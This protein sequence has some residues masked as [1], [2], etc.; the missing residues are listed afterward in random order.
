M[1]LVYG[2]AHSEHIKIDAKYVHYCIKLDLDHD[3][4]HRE[5]KREGGSRREGIQGRR[6][7]MEENEIKRDEEEDEERKIEEKD[8]ERGREKKMRKGELNGRN[9]RRE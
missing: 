7:N 8:E 4:H 6:K 1:L 5:T 2:T 3:Q 9:M